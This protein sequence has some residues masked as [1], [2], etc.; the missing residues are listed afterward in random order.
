M[1]KVYVIVLGVLAAA[2]AGCAS[3]P[4]KSQGP[5]SEAL[6]VAEAAG[7]ELQDVPREKIQQAAP[8]RKEHSVVPG[9]V[10]A[11][12]TATGDFAP[13]PGVSPVA[14]GALWALSL[15]DTGPAYRSQTNMFI[16]WMPRA[17]AKTPEEASRRLEDVVLQALRKALPNHHVGVKTYERTGAPYYWVEGPRCAE[18][19]EF[20]VP[21]R[22]IDPASWRVR[23][24]D[25]LGGYPAYAWDGGTKQHRVY[26]GMSHDPDGSRRWSPG[27]KGWSTRRQ[28]EVYQRFS[29]HLPEWIYLYLAPQ[30]GFISYPLVYGKGRALLF[31]E[32]GEESPGTRVSAARAE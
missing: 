24:P 5:K 2:V 7:L 28:L 30:K 8:A 29:E 14:A 10:L 11:A 27:W 31:I 32:P 9:A 1:N 3:A 18:G 4:Q 15:F 13:P 21:T 22:S 16:V 17:L 20:T 25:F 12:G 19:C 26:F 6:R 23:A